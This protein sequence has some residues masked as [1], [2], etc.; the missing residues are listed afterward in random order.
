MK[1]LFITE[2]RLK[3][4]RVLE[5]VCYYLFEILFYRIGKKDSIAFKRK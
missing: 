5:N 4:H 2:I 1:I 3:K